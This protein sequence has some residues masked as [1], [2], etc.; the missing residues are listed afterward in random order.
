MLFRSVGYLLARSA[1]APIR[2]IVK[3]AEAITASHIHKRLPVRNERDE[4]GELTLTFNALLERLDK[5][6]SAQKMFVSHVSHELRTPMAALLAE[7]DL[8]LLRNRSLNEYQMAIG[9]AKQ[10]ADR[11]VRLIN[12]LLDLAKS[13]YEAQQIKMKPIRLDE[14]LLDS[15]DLI[16]RAHPDYHIELIFD[17][18][19]EDDDVLT[20]MANSYLLTTALVNLIENNCKYSDN[21]TSIVQISFWQKRTIVRFSDNGIGMSEKDKEHLFQLFY[22]GENRGHVEGYGIG[23]ALANKIIKL[24]GGDLTVHS[25]PGE[26][27][28]FVARLPHI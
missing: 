17:Q 27:T 20:V 12:G 11:I 22:R 10:D 21:K 5:S 7:L 23:M 13:D 15:I 9:N 26:G 28:T 4:L 24:H 16:L 14:L 18:E 6:F 25:K 19:A 3:E 1:L 8:A 2:V